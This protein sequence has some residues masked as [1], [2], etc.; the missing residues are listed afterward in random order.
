MR[1][2]GKP[3][4]SYMTYTEIDN[5]WSYCMKVS[6]S[7]KPGVQEKMLVVKEEVDSEI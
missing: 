1:A 2:K 5:D 7:G 4:E 6:T 3:Q